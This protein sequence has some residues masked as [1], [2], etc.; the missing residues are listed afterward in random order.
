[1]GCC[2]ECAYPGAPG[3]CVRAECCP[4]HDTADDDDRALDVRLLVS[5]V[6][7]RY[8]GEDDQAAKLTDAAI[9]R[10]EWRKRHGGKG[11]AKCRTT[12]PVADFGRSAR[13]ADGL[14]PVC[15]SCRRVNG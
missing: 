3:V 10:L 11:C 1:M 2:E 13:E 15:K 8:D 5:R 14:N 12:K 9:R 7:S 6:A 4:C